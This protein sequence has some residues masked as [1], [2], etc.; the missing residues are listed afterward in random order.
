VNLDDLSQLE[1]ARLPFPVT[2]AIGDAPELGDGRTMYGHFSTFGQPYEVDSAMEGRFLETVAPGA[3]T[4]TIRKSMA[5]KAPM[6]VLFDHGQDPQV[7]NMIL[8]RIASLSEDEQGAAYEVGL[9]DGI[10][11]LLMNGLRAGAY[12]SSFRFS[13]QSDEWNHRPA[14]SEANPEGIPERRITEAQVYEFGPVT[15]PAN[16]AA[17]AGV[18][19][20][21][22]A[23]YRRSRDPESFETL[24][25]SAQV[26]R[27][28]RGAASPEPPP[29]TAPQ[30]TR[31]DTPA[32]TPTPKENRAMAEDPTPEERVSRIGELH[33]GL[34]RL[35]TEY[36][37]TLPAAVQARWDTDKAE[38]ARLEADQAAYE[39]RKAYVTS[40]SQRPQN[41]VTVTPPNVI[42]EPREDIYDVEQ[43]RH[44]TRSRDEYAQK[45]RDYARRSID[46]A[47]M[48]KG[49]DLDALTHI[50][51]YRDEGAEGAGDTAL[52][53]VTT[54]G[55]PYRRYF[56]K[57]LAGKESMATPEEKRA[58]ALAVTGTTTTGGFAVPY[59]FDPTMI[60][61]G[62]WTA[63]NPYRAT[64]RQETITNGN[65]WRTVTVGAITV[66]YGLEASPATEGGPT[67]GQ[68]TYTVQTCKGFATLSIETMQDRPDI[69]EELT[70]VF[71]E[72]KDTYEE[73]QFTLGTGATVFPQGMFLNTAY[74]AVNTATASTTV[75]ADFTAAEAALPLRFRARAAW[76][77]S[78]PT[79][80]TLQLADTTYRYWSGAGIQ[81]PGAINGQLNPMTPPN[82]S[83]NTGLYLLGYPVWET[84]SA[85]STLTTTGSI[86]AVLVDPSSYII[87][88]RIGMNVEVIPQMFDATTSFPTL[89][90]G[91][92]TYWRNT[93][94]SVNADAG[95]Q[96][97]VA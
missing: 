91:V 25:R 89:Q 32:V 46:S 3:F 58:A 21:T 66:S 34:D 56:N 76:F 35:S 61:I 27:T 41:C 49:A 70:K 26:A 30:P 9:F 53:V 57:Y 64:C 8:G 45:L 60:H 72:S 50:I 79:I 78:R 83:S 23:F 54:G 22:D 74:T 13:V 20:T 11:D 73:N 80:R 59:V 16:P 71:A 38:L 7:G 87:V 39:E 5:G 88:D 69:G 31:S 29:A 28:P 43:L 81:F 17:T 86:N 33:S 6:R 1:P 95:R 84:P 36:T 47:K 44:S 52:R 65:N 85:T 92:L 63:Q 62:A 94:K 37:G 82:G 15:F 10:P 14:R 75:L 2:R 4:Q 77:M 55:A 68:P 67:F 24:L 97:K 12:G 40:L 19:S 51:E 93:A 48:P 90:R 18:R 42:L 96:V